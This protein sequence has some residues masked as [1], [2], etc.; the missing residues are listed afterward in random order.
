MKNRNSS[1]ILGALA[2]TLSIVLLGYYLLGWLPMMLFALGFVGGFI[3]WIAIPTSFSFSTIRLAYFLTLVL[4]VAHKYEEKTKDFFPELSKI[5]GVPVPDANSVG[6]YLLYAAAGAWLLIPILVKN[7]R[8]FGY[9]LA[10]TF[11]TSMAVTELAHFFLPFLTAKPYA[12][13]PGMVTASVL[14]P[15][16]WFGLAKMWQNR[17]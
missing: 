13:F 12:Y 11:F 1:V 16:G 5:T 10:W 7:G 3:L 8:Q 15:A 17:F 9:Y 4:F 6:V 2:L 14:A